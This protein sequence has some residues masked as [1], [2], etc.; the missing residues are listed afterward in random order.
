MLKLNFASTS[1][2]IRAEPAIRSTALTICTQV[3]PFMP[4]T[5]T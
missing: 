5:V 3:V 4:P 1:T 2:T